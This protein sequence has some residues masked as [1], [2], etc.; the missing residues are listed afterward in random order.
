MA[1]IIEDLQTNSV[2]GWLDEHAQKLEHWSTEIWNYAELG[3]HEFKSSKLLADQLENEGFTIEMGVAGMPTAFVATW[4][5]GGPV[6]GILGEYD[7]LPGLSQKLVA[8]KNR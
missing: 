6:V 4:G 8:K 1:K 2:T 3:L 7:A 5:T